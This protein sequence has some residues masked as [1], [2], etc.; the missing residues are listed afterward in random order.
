MNEPMTRTIAN[1]QI[2]PQEQL[3]NVAQLVNRLTTPTRQ[4]T[5]QPDN[6]AA[7]KEQIADAGRQLAEMV[8]AYLAGELAPIDDD[9]PF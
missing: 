7:S 5:R 4:N 3:I 6:F 2:T 8:L 9:L 1:N